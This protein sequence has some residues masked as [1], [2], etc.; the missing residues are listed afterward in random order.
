M[1]EFR[2]GGNRE[3]RGLKATMIKCSDPYLLL[4]QGSRI[5]DPARLLPPPSAAKTT[6]MEFGFVQAVEQQTVARDFYRATTGMNDTRIASHLRGIDF[7][8]PVNIVNIP[9]GTALTQFN[10]PGRVG[11]Y[12]APPGTPRIPWESTH[13]DLSKAAIPLVR[14]LVLFNQQQHLSLTTGR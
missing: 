8:Q 11:N 7:S 12:Y 13:L 6:Q 14:L 9:A 2:N 4:T 3:T 1:A 5:T 10:L